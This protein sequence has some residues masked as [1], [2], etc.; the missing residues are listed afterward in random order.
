MQGNLHKAARPPG[1]GLCVSKAHI[2]RVQ[3]KALLKS[4]ME[5]QEAPKKKFYKRWWV[6]VLAVIVLFI[7]IGIAGGASTTPTKVGSNDS[8]ASTE[9]VNSTYKVGDQ[10]KLG[11]SILTVNN[12]AFSSGSQYSKPQ[13]GNEWVNVNLT[14]QNTGSSQQYVTTLGQMF[15]R[16]GQGNSYQVAVTD[17]AIENPN[18]S[19]D[20]TVIANSKR[21]GWVGFEIPKGTSGLQ[22]QYNGSMFGGGTI[23][24]DLGR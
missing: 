2:Q 7:I 17:K 21:T 4:P 20:G 14:I 16:D 9:P 18:N 8:S 15:V 19:L 12:V 1:G 24:V 6:W 3:L 22:F 23:V 13:S 11:S 5:N 10:I